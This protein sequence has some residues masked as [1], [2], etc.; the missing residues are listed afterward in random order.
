[1][2]KF[3]IELSDAAYQGLQR[4]V[5]R[6]NADNNAAHTV[7]A[8]VDLHLRELA[9]QDEIVRAAEQ[10]QR[11]AQETAAAALQAERQRLLDSVA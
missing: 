7:E 9:V 8:W 3:E 2:A 11:E 6:Y 10:L 1:M 4:L 5:T